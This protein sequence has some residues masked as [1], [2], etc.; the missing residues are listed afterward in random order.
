MQQMEQQFK[1]ELQ[2]LKDEMVNHKQDFTQH[3]K[4][5]RDDTAH[6]VALRL[7]AEQEMKRLQ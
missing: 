6:A 7:N 5:M 2:R 4:Q 1:D 3:L